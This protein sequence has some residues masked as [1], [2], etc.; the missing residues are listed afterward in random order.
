MLSA[1]GPGGTGAGAWGSHG[2]HGSVNMGAIRVDIDHCMVLQKT[3]HGD[4]AP[5][6][7]RVDFRVCPSS[8]ILGAVLVSTNAKLSVN[9]IT[10]APSGRRKSP[11]PPLLPLRRMCCFSMLYRG[12]FLGHNTF[13]GN[14]LVLHSSSS[15][16][17][18]FRAD[19]HSDGALEGEGPVK[20]R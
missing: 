1:C 19:S 8:I 7:S 10:L 4:I 11:C 15:A 3:A 17:E 16:G 14:D 20:K 9:I 2:A 13:P 18:L 12:G 5:M 6:R